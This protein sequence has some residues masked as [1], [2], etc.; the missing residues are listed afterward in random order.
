MPYSSFLC[1][2]APGHLLMQAYHSNA[3]LIGFIGVE[4]KLQE[5]V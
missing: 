4:H 1:A 2:K 5:M 3:I